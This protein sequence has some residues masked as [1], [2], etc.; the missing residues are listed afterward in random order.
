MN[1]RIRSFAVVVEDVEGAVFHA[2]L[3]FDGFNLVSAQ[4]VEF[5]AD[6]PMRVCE[7]HEAEDVTEIIGFVEFATEEIH[8]DFLGQFLSLGDT[9]TLEEDLA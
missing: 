6:E 2:L 1:E 3:T 9:C 5:S 7:R 4:R 8:G